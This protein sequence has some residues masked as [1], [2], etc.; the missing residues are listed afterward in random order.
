M[1]QLIELRKVSKKYTLG[2][3][4]QTVLQNISLKIKPGKLVA[5]LGPS[6]AGKSTLLNLIA[7]MDK[8]TSGKVLI[9]GQDLSQCSERQLADFRAKNIGFVFQFYNIL[10]TLTVLENIQLVE[11]LK[12]LS[13]QHFANL[14]AEAVLKQ[15]GLER[16]KTK[17]P[18]QLSG[19]EQ[20]RISIARAI[21]KQPKLLLCDEPT[22]ALDSK[23]GTTILK[24][25]KQQVSDHCSVIIV[26]HNSLIAEIADQVIHL[27]NGQIAS[28]NINRQPKRIEEIIW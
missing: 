10:P 5:V 27:K 9:D 4:Q 12:P 25:L 15:V 17:F 2:D 20:Q 19:G 23:T 28:N 22:G 6:G 8:P 24:L 3:Q 1:K 26:T 14:S 11:S 16:H 13:R 7:G 21:Y 18:S